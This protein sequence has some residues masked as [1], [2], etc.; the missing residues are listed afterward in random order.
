MLLRVPATRGKGT[1][2]CRTAHPHTCPYP[3]GTFLT[4][5]HTL[6]APS[7]TSTWV[8]E[9][10]RSQDRGI[11][12]MDMLGAVFLFPWQNVLFS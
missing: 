2:S 4:R 8:H 1:R 9:W 11:V 5:A 3:A 7:A 12:T 10:S 6:Q